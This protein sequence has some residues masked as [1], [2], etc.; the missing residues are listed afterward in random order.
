MFF[1]F[2]FQKFIFLEFGI[3]ISNFCLLFDL[4][5]LKAFIFSDYLLV[6]PSTPYFILNFFLLTRS[7][8]NC[9][10]DNPFPSCDFDHLI[11]LLLLNY[12]FSSLFLSLMTSSFC[13]SS[14]HS[15]F[16]TAIFSQSWLRRTYITSFHYFAWFSDLL[17]DFW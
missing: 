12:H 15:P 8:F 7:L 1:S 14:S 2:D 4:I 5:F 13:L 6:L 3:N 16:F 9:A 17:S 11:S 10:Y